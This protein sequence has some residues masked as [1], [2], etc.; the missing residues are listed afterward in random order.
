[1][2]T[3]NETTEPFAAQYG[4]LKASLPGHDVRWLAGLRDG[5]MARFA[6]SG[7]PT[8]RLESWKYTS[9]AALSGIDFQAPGAVAPPPP[10]GLPASLLANGGPRLVFVNGRIDAGLSRLDDLP[11]GLSMVPLSATI[12]GA[13]GSIESHL[14]RIG[15]DMAQPM[16]ALNTA[17]ASEGYVVRVDPGV[18]IEAPI[19]MVFLGGLSEV[20]VAYHPRNLVLVGAGA[21]IDIVEHHVGAGAAAYLANGVFEARV[22][23][24][25][26]LA[27][28]KVQD[29]G[30]DA[31]HL[32][33]GHVR[34]A[35]DA[36]FEGFCLALG[37][38]LSR[39]ETTILLEGEGAH[40]GLAGAYLMR[41][42]QHCDTTTVVEHRVPNTT[43]KEVFKGVLDDHARAVFQ[44][45]LLV[46]RGAQ[47][48]D[49]HQLSK[50]LLLS[51]N[52]EIDAKPELEIYADDVKCSH[53]ATSGQ[54]DE[55]ALFYLR[56]R[57]IPDVQARA[58]LIQA[59]LGE[60]TDLVGI[61][62]LRKVMTERVL[63][64]LDSN[65]D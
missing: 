50:T 43:C 18:Q 28:I 14:G 15:E 57:G 22:D 27:H 13:P 60:A 59:F 52:A 3:S 35:K 63:A 54:I 21:G 11:D 4:A 58:L 42:R 37:A 61:G 8:Q 38:R 16:S 23:A 32:W 51:D 7:L 65:A 5:A 20:A 24:G 41:G 49:A 19:E 55:T 1:M 39:C 64:W 46:A 12:E 30:P 9:L 26:R 6:K 47:H 44:G 34:L 17:F 40:A 36:R 29:E 56:S 45:R 62:A 53:G 2:P 10:A 33:T 25:G 48:T 31:F